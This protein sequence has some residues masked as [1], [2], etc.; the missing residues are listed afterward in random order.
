MS[1]QTKTF[2]KMDSIMVH[3]LLQENSKLKSE[4]AKMQESRMEGEPTMAVEAR[5]EDD[6]THLPNLLQNNANHRSQK[7]KSQAE[8]EDAYPGVLQREAETVMILPV[9]R[10]TVQNLE[11]QPKTPKAKT[12]KAV[13][14]SP[15][16]SRQ[17][18]PKC[19]TSRSPKNM[20]RGTSRSP[21]NMTCGTSRKSPQ[22]TG[23]SPRR[24]A[25]SITRLMTRRTPRNAAAS[26]RVGQS[27]PKCD[28]P[29]WPVSQRWR[30]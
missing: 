22:R 7:I 1:K 19:G 12:P 24:T 10:R 4:I 2:F 20:T 17:K 9:K 18:N 25:R 8:N 23:K 30:P 13:H 16:H 3:D 28:A 5:A 15:Q 26:R 27:T 14:F 21:K 11:C 29:C 6:Q